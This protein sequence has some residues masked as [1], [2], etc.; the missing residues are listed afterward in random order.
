MGDLFGVIASIGV[1]ASL[2]I[3]T[4]QT[5]ELARQSAINNGIAGASAMYNG[6]ERLHYIETFMATAPELHAYFYGGADLPTQEEARARVLTVTRMLADALDYG[7]RITTLN[8][9]MER[10]E[11]WRDFALALRASSPAL[12]HVVE[13]HPEWWTVLSAHW[14]ANPD[15]GG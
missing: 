2:L 10:Y 9:E 6:L 15:T 11:G 12:V 4:W 7:L 1:V 13:E 8:P 14:S 3:S 5:R